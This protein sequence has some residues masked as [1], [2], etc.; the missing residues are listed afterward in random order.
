MK[1]KS[2]LIASTIVASALSIAGTSAAQAQQQYMPVLSYRSGPY[3]PNGIPIANGIVDYLKLVNERGGINGVKLL[4]EEC[5]TGYDTAR[6]VECYERLK[7][8]NGGAAVVQPWATGATFA[9]M[10]KSHVDKIP[11][12]TFGYGRSESA[13]G[14]VFKWSFPVAGTYWV[15]ADVIAQ[16]IG[17]REGG[18]DKLK[19][20]KIALIYHDSPYGKESIPV[21]QERS[22][23]HGF[24][25]QIL[26]VTAPGVEQKSTWLQIRQSRPDY[27][28]LWGYGVMNSTALREAQATGFPRDRM[29]G[30]WWAGAEPDVRDVG[31]AAKGYNAVALQSSANMDAKVVK[32]T[33]EKLHAKGLG[34]GPKDE[35]GQVLWLR[36]ATS[37]M[38]AVEGIRAAQEKF[39]KGK[40]MTGEQVRWGLENLNLTDEKIEAIGFT[41]LIKPLTTSCADHMGSA[42]T[43]LSTWDGSTWKVSG[44]WMQADP[45]V[46]NPLVKSNSE[47]YA[48]ERKL[49]PRTA[50]DCKS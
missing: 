24:N 38:L 43:R 33:L 44:D 1:L 11:L 40:V 5:E 23:M 26:P 34:T 45:Q 12:I 8:K 37:S 41:G 27:V 13:D 7:D 17:K 3:A 6:S 19:G 16:A 14:H 50:E 4:I 35:V 21:L 25:L 2:H 18:M 15:A 20:K 28:I 36:G 10:E 30:S 32:E 48:A 9:L 39:G 47:K 42:W 29:Y 22:K 31:A 46:L 49:T